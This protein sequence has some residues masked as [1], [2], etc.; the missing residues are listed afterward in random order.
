M[1][2]NKPHKTR[3][4]E[5]REKHRT[6][7]TS[8]PR[9]ILTQDSR[10][11]RDRMHPKTKSKKNTLQPNQDK[12]N[13]TTPKQQ[14]H[15]KTQTQQPNKITQRPKTKRNKNTMILPQK[16]KHKTFKHSIKACLQ[17]LTS[18]QSELQIGSPT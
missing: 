14:T 3:T 16:P 7:N 11:H 2:T 13:P 15:K 1:A 18:K 6:R 12:N 5:R 10:Q 17:T 4:R 8:S 9:R